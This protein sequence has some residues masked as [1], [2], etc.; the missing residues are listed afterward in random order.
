M[1]NFI[2]PIGLLVTAIG[3]FVGFT[4]PMYQSTKTLAAEAALYDDALT[5]A[6]DLRE[7]RDEFMDKYKTFTPDNKQRL[8]RGLPDNVD[9]IRLI[10]D[11]NNIATRHG[12]SLKNVELGDVSDARTARNALSVGASGDTVG[13][14]QVSFTLS[15]VYG[16]FL[17]FIQDL[18]HSLRIVDIEDIRFN[19][20]GPGA[21]GGRSDYSFTVRTY[22]LR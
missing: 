1:I 9:N 20:P 6:Q 21:I 13:S 8:L 22:W 19:A 16:D 18:E 10:I 4:N 12:L 3:L 15:A 5:K 2:I 14:V 7:Q 11:I 17:S